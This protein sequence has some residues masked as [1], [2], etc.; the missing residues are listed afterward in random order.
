[1]LFFKNSGLT[2]HNTI[3]LNYFEHGFFKF[4][5]QLSNEF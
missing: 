3:I 2:S 5:P 1:M 4:N